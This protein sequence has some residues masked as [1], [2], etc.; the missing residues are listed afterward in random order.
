M[1]ISVI[2]VIRGRKKKLPPKINVQ[3]Q[4]YHPNW[5]F[6]SLKMEALIKILA[7]FSILIYYHE[8]NVIKC[9]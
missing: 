9:L 5:T 3:N 1:G 6:F 4:K 8:I 7:I 2:F